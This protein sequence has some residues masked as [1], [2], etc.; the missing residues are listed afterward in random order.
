MRRTVLYAI[1]ATGLLAQAGCSGDRI[2]SVYNVAEAP[3]PRSS[4]RVLT[5]EET[6]RILTKTALKEEWAVTEETTHALQCTRRW[7]NHAA[8]IRIAFDDKGYSITL[9]SSEN[10]KEK[11]GNIHR[12]YNDYVRRLQTAIDLNLSRAV[13]E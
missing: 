5:A 1:L 9:I 10:L 3:V 6:A 7:Q 2:Q 11:D 13:F 12:K 4:T 8:T